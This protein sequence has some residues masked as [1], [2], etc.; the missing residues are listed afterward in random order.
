MRLK[1]RSA[2]HCAFFAHGVANAETSAQHRAEVDAHTGPDRRPVDAR[3]GH[4]LSGRARIHRVPFGA[5]RVDDFAG[6]QAQR[7][8]RLTVVLAFR[9]RVTDHAA[10]VHLDARLWLLGHAAARHV[11]LHDGA[12]LRRRARAERVQTRGRR[13]GVMRCVVHRMRDG[14]ANVEYLVAD[15]ERSRPSVGAHAVRGA[16]QL[17]R[18]A[19]PAARSPRPASPVPPGHRRRAA[20]RSRG[21]APRAHGSRRSS[22]SR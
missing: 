9:L 14:P 5:Q 20:G 7:L 12:L 19:C 17:A 22:S 18:R 8:Q 15:G 4:V 2:N 16:V 6:P 3:D 10:P 21:A 13:R 11:D 1:F